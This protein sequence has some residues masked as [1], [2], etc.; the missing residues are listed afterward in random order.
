MCTQPEL[1]QP[2]SCA[3]YLIEALLSVLTSV[4][5]F[6]SFHL[7][8]WFRR[9]HLKGWGPKTPSLFHFYGFPLPILH[10]KGWILIIFGS[11]DSWVGA[12]HVSGTLLVYPTTQVRTKLT[13][14]RLCHLH[15]VIQ[16]YVSNLLRSSTLRSSTKGLTVF[17]LR[18]DS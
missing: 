15:F 18:Y 14:F 9:N 3:C 8:K 13:F 17:I 5:L 11:W 4:I 1:I 12:R 16:G 2:Y 10:R 6:T 7:G